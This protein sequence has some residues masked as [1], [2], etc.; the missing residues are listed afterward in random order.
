MVD[1][2]KI[3]RMPH[4]AWITLRLDFPCWRFEHNGGYSASGPGGPAT[5]YLAERD[6]RRL[7]GHTVTELR[8]LLEAEPHATRPALIIVRD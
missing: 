4:A 6:G 3:D 8:A 2:H 5:V 7:V 1:R